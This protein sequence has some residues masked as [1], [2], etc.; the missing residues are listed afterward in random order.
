MVEQVLSWGRCH[1][2][3]HTRIIP[4]S[5]EEAREVVRSNS[6]ILPFGLGRSYGDSCLNDNGMLIDTRRLDHFVSFDE[7]TGLLVCEGGV[8]LKAILELLLTRPRA[9]GG[10]WFLPVVPGT[11]FVTVGGAIANDV[12]G[13]NHEVQG[14]FGRHVDWL[15]LARSDGELLRCSNTENEELFRATIGGLGLT[16]LITQAAI[17]LMEI[18]G[19]ML[20]VEH[21]RLRNLDDYFRVA[22]ESRADWTHHAAW[23]DVLAKRKSAGRGIYTRSRFTKCDRPSPAVKGGPGVPIELP[24]S[25]IRYPTIKLFN[26]L[27]RRKLFAETRRETCTPYEPAFFPLDG[28]QNWNRIYGPKGFYQYQCVVPRDGAASSIREMLNAMAGAG[29]GSFL[30][31]LKEFGEVASPGL[32]SFPMAGTTLAVDFPNEGMQTLKL[33]DHLDAITA[34]AGGRVYVAK[35]GRADPEMLARAYPQL[36]RFRQSI[37]PAFSS[38]F[39]RR[40]AVG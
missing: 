1:R 34:A 36:D 2:F 35:D 10:N 37:D 12:H 7:Q 31:V 21:I 14:T 18:P 20:D 17:R 40:N 29:Q 22:E 32:L 33:L 11:K 26:A 16:G 27:Y 4:G 15:E 23:V 30:T 25:L 8:T 24:T 9:D 19:P 6:P 3:D 38:T 28:L 39:W 13:K 5:I